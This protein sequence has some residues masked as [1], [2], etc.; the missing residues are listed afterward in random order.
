[1]PPRVAE[2]CHA[3]DHAEQFFYIMLGSAT[4]EIKGTEHALGKNQ[5]I[6]ATRGQ[7]H[8][9][10]NT[11]AGVVLLLISAPHSRGNRVTDELIPA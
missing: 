9:I 7:M 1:M 5:G 4:I 10:T 11:G 2:V 8:Q 3:H 6:S